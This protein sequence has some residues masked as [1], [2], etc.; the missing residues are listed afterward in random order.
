MSR[1]WDA[2]TGALVDTFAGHD[3]RVFAPAFSSAG[4]QLALHTASLDGTTITWDVSGH[5]RLEQ[6]FRTGAG[7]DS[8][9]TGLAPRIAVSPDG[10]LLAA[11]DPAGI[12]ILDAT[13]HA[14]VR[15]IPAQQPAGSFN[16]VWSPDGTRLAVTGSGTA[17]VNLYDTSTWRAVGPTEGSLDGPSAE[18]AANGFEID[19]D[20]PAETGRRTNTARAVAFSPD[21]RELVAGTDD[22]EVW[23]WDA[24]SG[25]GSGRPL[26]VSGPVD[27][28]GFN[29][30]SGALA[31]A[32]AGP[33][34]GVASV[35]ADGTQTLQ[36]TVNVDDDY[37]APGPVAFSPDGAV[38]A[39][40]GGKGDVRFWD[41]VTGSEIGPRVVTAAGYVV[42]LAWT[43]SG[44]TLVSAGSDGTVRLIDAATK[45][46]ADVLPGQQNLWVDARPSPDG[47]RLYVA[48]ETGQAFDWSI[49]PVAW[50]KD[51][52]ALAG[53]T[54]TQSE[55]TQ[56]LPNRPYAP[57]C[58]P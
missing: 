54:L 28:L 29:P 42:D 22:G 10:R 46:A 44:T 3:G 39:T 6:S 13:T 24:T 53:R 21:S 40:G 30:V 26:Q 50:A 34:G 5:R 51:A 7:F 36:F 20:N 35:Y 52:C 9:L 25:T 16:M 58:T 8:G 11:N 38:L 33:S 49:D 14:V 55:W 48:Y 15:R 18:R 47:S 45:I 37:G 17:M 41:A 12:T 56:Y 27:G 43:P 1:I 32:Y 2:K 57:A 31:V 19:V 23:T 4:G